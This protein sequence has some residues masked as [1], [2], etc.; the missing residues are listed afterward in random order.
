V[1]PDALLDEIQH[2][3][4]RGHCLPTESATH[5]AN[6]P[7]LL[8]PS[9]K[10]LARIRA[11][12]HRW[13]QRPPSRAMGLLHVFRIVWGHSSNVS[14]PANFVVWPTRCRRDDPER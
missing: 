6:P 14:A 11:Q 1:C 7:D 12:P 9:C 8:C 4:T 10:P 2:L 5:R 13:N 3:L